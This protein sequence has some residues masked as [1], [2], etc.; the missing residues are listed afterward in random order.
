[1]LISYLEP[2]FKITIWE[3]TAIWKD[4]NCI[5]NGLNLISDCDLGLNCYPRSQAKDSLH[6][7]D[8]MAGQVV[9]RLADRPGWSKKNVSTTSLQNLVEY[10]C[11]I[12]WLHGQPN[13]VGPANPFRHSLWFWIHYLKK[14]KKP[15]HSFKGH[16]WLPPIIKSFHYNY[17]SI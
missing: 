14:K 11:D 1:M 4:Q 3:R 15:L 16:V 2:Y 17:S 5:P 6:G 7:L 8:R 13:S 9:L 12:I 10:I